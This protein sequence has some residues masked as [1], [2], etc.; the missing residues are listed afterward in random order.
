MRGEVCQDA[1][2]STGGSSPFNL[3]KDETANLE[4]YDCIVVGGSIYAGRIHPKVARFCARNLDVLLQKKLGLF[5]CC[6]DLARVD[7][8]MAGAFDERLREHAA[9]VEHFG[10]EYNFAKMNLLIRTIIRLIAK[11]HTSQSH[12]AEDNIERFAEALR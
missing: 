12:I 8:Q 6:A 2:G 7:E 3:A 5:I 1:A 11:I 4:D 9:V 10:Y